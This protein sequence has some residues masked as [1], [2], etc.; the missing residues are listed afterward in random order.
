MWGYN[1]TEKRDIM[2]RIEGKIDALKELFEAHI[3]KQDE[4]FKAMEKYWDLKF[5]IDTCNNCTAAQRIDQTEEDIKSIYKHNNMIV[6]A[7]I[8]IGII[9]PYVLPKLIG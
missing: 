5:T 9:L 4:Q 6:G 1:I 3:V 7:L 2:E 8:I